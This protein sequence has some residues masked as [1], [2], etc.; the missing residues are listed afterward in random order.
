MECVVTLDTGGAVWASFIFRFV[1]YFFL[2]IFLIIRL[3]V[4]SSLSLFIQCYIPVINALIL[5]LDLLTFESLW[6]PRT[7]CLVSLDPML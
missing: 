4:P 1:G 3:F 5:A 6:M 2:L 7:V